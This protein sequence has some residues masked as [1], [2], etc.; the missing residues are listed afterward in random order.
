MSACVF[1]CLCFLFVD[2]CVSLFV[3]C[4][5]VCHLICLFIVLL[6]SVLLF[7]QYTVELAFMSFMLLYCFHTQCKMMFMSVHN[8]KYGLCH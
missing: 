5:S 6:M 3:S 4:L 1:V 7:Q 8:N 2:L